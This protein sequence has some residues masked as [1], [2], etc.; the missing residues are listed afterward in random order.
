[1]ILIQLYGAVSRYR[2]QIFTHMRILRSLT[3][4]VMRRG[5]VDG[6]PDACT[7]FWLG[8]F[9][10]PCFVSFCFFLSPFFFLL[11]LGRGSTVPELPLEADSSWQLAAHALCLLVSSS[12]GITITAHGHSPRRHPQALTHFKT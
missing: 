2:M 1:M 9:F 11:G 8:F 5:G 4:L 6:A 7:F 12:H 3:V 10:F